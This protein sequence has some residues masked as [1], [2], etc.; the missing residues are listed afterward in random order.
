MRTLRHALFS[1]AWTEAELKQVAKAINALEDTRPALYLRMGQ[2]WVCSKEVVGGSDFFVASR[3]DEK[4]LIGRNVAELAEK[5]RSL[6]GQVAPGGYVSPRTTN[7]TRKRKTPPNPADLVDA[8]MLGRFEEIARTTEPGPWLFP[9]PETA[10]D[11]FE[12]LPD[13]FTF[14][15]LA[16]AADRLG[17]ASAVAVEHLRTFQRFEM[18]STAEDTFLKTGETPYF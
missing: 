17:I 5:I 7:D 9:I 13:A 14:D 18:V 4:V 3:L 16:E 10:A 12:A 11:L 15:E 6:R 1:G 2:P 8:E